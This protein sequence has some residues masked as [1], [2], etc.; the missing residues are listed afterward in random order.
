MSQAESSERAPWTTFRAAMKV[1]AKWA[2]FDHAAVAPLPSAA[3][4]AIDRWA[5]QATEEG[6]TCWPEWNRRVE[7][8]R[9]LAA[10]LLGADASEIALVHSTTEGI[11]LVAEGY[12]WQSGDNVVTLANEFPS[13]LYPW[14]NLASRG[15][16]TRRVE[17]E[18]GRVDL[19][20]LEAACDSCTRIITVSWVGYLSGWRIALD[21]V[22]EIARRKNVLLFVDAIQ[23]LGAF[24]LDVRAT[25]VDFLAADGHKWLLGPEGAGL[26]YIRREH[27]E[28]L[29]PVGVGW[30]SV[31]HASDYG[32]IELSFRPSAARY[33][34]GTQNMAG[35][36]ALAESLELLLGFGLEAIAERVLAITDLACERLHEI[37]AVV[38]SIRE[39]D[40][41]SGIVS[42]EL[43]GQDAGAVR[44]RCLK[45]GVALAAR[46]GKLRISPHA[47]VDESDVR[48]LVAALKR[49][50]GRRT[51]LLTRPTRKRGNLP[52]CHAGTG[53]WLARR[54]RFTKPSLA[55]RVSLRKPSLAPGGRK[56]TF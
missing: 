38:A 29:R 22:V 35:F 12:P 24:P 1:A 41:R 44:A 56:K 55:R 28:R 30:H 53:L 50:A 34:G 6:D 20:Q 42:F 3:A 46:G 5:A 23:G 17:A 37:G 16:E 49:E 7:E 45:R 2:Y 39:G 54:V 40:H 18:G 10:R 51:S 9:T 13:N 27:L 15:V 47:Y 21:D 25:P 11:G 8:A 32:R 48:R 26:F 36:L 31:A 33:E 43:P 4:A 14:M 52:R 19:A